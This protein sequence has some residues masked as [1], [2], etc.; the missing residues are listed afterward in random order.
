LAAYEVAGKPKKDTTRLA[1]NKMPKINIP[2][3]R[4]TDFIL[5]PPFYQVEP[6]PS[7][8]FYITQLFLFYCTTLFIW[9][10]ANVANA[11]STVGL[12]HLNKKYDF[13]FN[14]LILN[15]NQS[16]S[17]FLIWDVIWIGI[18]SRIS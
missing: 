7:D 8:H 2:A 1:H 11:D 13:R 12:T 15:N 9:L 14:N 18:I 10:G 3:L 5:L 6:A 16:I 17:R 4:K